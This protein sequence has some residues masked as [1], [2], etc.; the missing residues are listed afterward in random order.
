MVFLE[1]IDE[2]ESLIAMHQKSSYWD[3][4]R[5]WYG[6]NKDGDM[7]I[8][9][10]CMANNLVNRDKYAAEHPFCELCFERGLAVPVEEIHHKLPL[11]EGGTHDRS[12]L[13]ALCK[14]CHSKIHA[15]RGDRW[16]D[17]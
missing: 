6:D 10:I 1:L 15:K 9:I 17:R 11:S 3:F 5:E 7:L 16:H 2:I 13:I 14:S 8:D 12:N 4:K